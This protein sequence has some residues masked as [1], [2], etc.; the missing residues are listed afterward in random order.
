MLGTGKPCRYWSPG[1][2]PGRTSSCML[3]YP[4][5]Q[6][7]NLPGC[8]LSPMV[9]GYHK[10]NQ[11]KS[12]APGPSADCSAEM[13]ILLGSISPG[14]SNL[15]QPHGCPRKFPGEPCR[16]SVQNHIL[17]R[18]AKSTSRIMLSLGCSRIA[19]TLQ[20]R[21]GRCVWKGQLQLQQGTGKRKDVQRQFIS[22]KILALALHTCS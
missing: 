6:E 12:F 18:S 4:A 9:L 8:T 16:R 7:P 19:Q 15:A 5:G 2:G 14:G 1:W 3:S 17:G 10:G 13:R 22:S 21:A 11:D 20:R